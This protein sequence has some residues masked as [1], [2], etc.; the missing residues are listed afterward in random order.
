METTKTMSFP[1]AAAAA[2]AGESTTPRVDGPKQ[3][4]Q[5]DFLRLLVTQLKSQNPL[6]PIENEA[7]IA[8]LAQFSQLEQSAKLVKVMEQT[9]DMQQSAMQFGLVPVVGRQVKVDGSVV[10]LGAGPATVEYEL[11][12]R[13]EVIQATIMDADNQVI[14]VLTDFNRPAGVH[15]LL[16][17]GTDQFGRPQPTGAYRVSLSAKDTGGRA[18]DA[19]TRSLVTVSGVRMEDNRPLV[20]AGDRTFEPSDIVELR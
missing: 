5:D 12:S 4:G 8:Q 2:S 14:R 9:R 15:Q 19:T 1:G 11:K 3:L 16:W 13:A 17:D 10:E 7:F 20:L 6:K 18:V